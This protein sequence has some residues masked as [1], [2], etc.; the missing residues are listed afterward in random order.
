MTQDGEVIQPAM[1]QTFPI[2]GPT[3]AAQPVYAVNPVTGLPQMPAPGGTLVVAPT[4]NDSG[5]ET[6]AT[7][8]I[9]LVNHVD[10]LQPIVATGTGELTKF[11]PALGWDAPSAHVVVIASQ[12]GGFQANLYIDLYCVVCDAS[13]DPDTLYESAGIG[14]TLL[15]QGDAN[16]QLILA[17]VP[18]FRSATPSN[19][20]KVL[21]WAQTSVN[22]TG[23]PVVVTATAI[24]VQAAQIYTV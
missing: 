21:L 23:N 20:L 15:K 5:T 22:I 14:K 3:I 2:T 13:L 18:V 11:D 16:Q 24:A 19:D 9:P 17:N 7:A 12:L 8:T 6:T 1:P 4:Y 10:P